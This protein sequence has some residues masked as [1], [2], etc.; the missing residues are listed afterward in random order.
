MIELRNLTKTFVLNGT[1]KTVADNVSGVFPTGRSVALLGR[2]GAGKSSLLKMI[3]GTM[4][5]T[6]GHI[7]SNGTISWPVGFGGSFHPDLSGAQ[8]TRFIARI[9]GADTDELLAFV[10]RFAE[11]GEHYHLPLRTY[12]AG[13]RSRLAFGVSVGIQF[14]TYLIDEVVAVGDAKFRQKSGDV[15]LA[16]LEYASAIVVTHSMPLVRR[17][18]NMG[19][20]LEH[21]R[22]RIYEDIEEAI[23][24]HERNMAV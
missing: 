14:D 19:A 3:A 23:E 17:L 16:R 13:M 10:E 4:D 7:L 9:Y 24:V 5:P 18:C 12:S 8:N 15:L 1:R 21:G 6:E 20:V 11:L 22:L 2:N